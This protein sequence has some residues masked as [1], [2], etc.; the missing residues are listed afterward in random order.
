MPNKY[1]FIVYDPIY[2]ELRN[3][4]NVVTTDQDLLGGI[5]GKKGGWIIRRM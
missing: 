2:T 3:A 5:N 4:N 1:E